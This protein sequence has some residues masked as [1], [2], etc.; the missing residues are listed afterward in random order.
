MPETKEGFHGRR[1]IPP[2]AR[3]TPQG[4][5]PAIPARTRKAPPAQSATRAFGERLDTE[6]IQAAK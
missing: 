2:G 1:I 5:V 6:T 4:G 3:L